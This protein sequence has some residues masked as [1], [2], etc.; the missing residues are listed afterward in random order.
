MDTNIDK[1]ILNSISVDA[2]CL[3]NPGPIEYKGVHTNS[4]RV[5]FN[6]GPIP[7]GTNN[8]AEFLAI[9]HALALLNKHNRNDAVYS[10]SQT[11]IVWVKNKKI[12]TQLK[13]SKNNSKIFELIKRAEYWLRQNTYS[14]PVLKWNTKSWGEISADF[15]RKK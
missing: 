1:P 10:D 13:P 3:G 9:V 15:G 2:S 6:V 4:K 7:G 11:A 14:N 5:L 12:N 8:I